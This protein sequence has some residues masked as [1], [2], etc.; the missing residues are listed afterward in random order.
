[1]KRQFFSSLPKV[2]R[3]VHIEMNVARNVQVDEPVAIVVGPGRAGAEAA[4][5]DSGFFGD[6]FESAIAQVAIKRVAAEA[7]DVDVRQ[8]VVVEVGDSH[9][10]APAFAGQSGQRW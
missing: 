3:V 4:G 10:H 1:M 5:G 8:A 6:I 2:G 7:G 9:A